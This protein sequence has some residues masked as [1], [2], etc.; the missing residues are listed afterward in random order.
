M[1]YAELA[2][3]ADTIVKDLRKR[4][5]TD[6]TRPLVLLEAT[7]DAFSVAAY[8]G[9]LR[10]GW[11][12]I[13]DGGGMAAPDTSIAQTY[14]PN[15]V[16]QFCNN[17]WRTDFGSMRQ[18]DLHPDLAVLLSKSGTTGAAK[19]VRL[20][21]H[22]LQSNA[23][24][25]ISYLK[26]RP[27][28]RT[29]TTLPFHYSYGM[30]VLHI[31]L[32][33]G[34]GVVLTERSIVEDGIWGLAKRHRVSALA[35]VPT[36]FELLNRIGFSEDWLP[37]FRYITQAGGKLD[38][39][40]LK[41][42]AH[43]ARDKGWHFFI[44]YG[45]TEAGPRMSFVPPE[46]ALDWG[47][48]IGRAIDGG[49]FHLSASD[50]PGSGDGSTTGEL[51]FEGPGVMM[52]Y[53][54]APM[55]LADGAGPSTLRTGDIA[56]R[57]DNGY[58]RLVGRASRFIK[59]FGLRIGCDEVENLLR[60]EGRRV[61]VSGSDAGLVIFLSDDAEPGSLA[62]DVAARFK[63]PPSAVVVRTLDAVPL[64]SSGKVDYRS[65]GEMAQQALSAPKPL[66]SGIETLLRTA[67]RTPE[68]DLDRSFVE[69]GGDSL[70]YLEVELFFS[71]RGTDLPE[72]WELRPLR[73]LVELDRP[74]RRSG[75]TWQSVPSDLIGRMEALVMVIALH[76]TGWPTG[77]GAYLLLILSG[78]SIA[79][80]QSEPLFAG[81]VFRTWRIMLVPIV[82]C[83]LVLVT[84]TAAVW[85]PVDWRWFLFL[86]NFVEDISPKELTPYW[87]VC[88]YVQIVLLF[89]LPFLSP[90]VRAFF[91]RSPFAAGLSSLAVVVLLAWLLQLDEVNF[92]SRHR[93]PV[94]ALE[95]FILGWCIYFARQFAQK[96]MMS[97][98]IGTVYVTH[99]SDLPNV[100]AVVILT[101]ATAPLWSLRLPATSWIARRL[102]QFGSL[103]MFV[104]LAHAPMISFVTR[105]MDLPEL[106]RFLAVLALS[107]LV[108]FVLKTA[109]T[110]IS[111]LAFPAGVSKM[112]RSAKPTASDA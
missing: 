88:A 7:N 93:H 79:R 64:L 43:C 102:M 92:S 26:V 46:D 5:P 70:S 23:T 13:L 111:S 104:Y 49:R 53:A 82:L 9:F 59:L 68:P 73:E 6:L 47:H 75:V 30:S 57:L 72:S 58:F 54:T 42:F 78:Y 100:I 84:M 67:L 27:D 112:R 65:L 2:E 25:I 41:S 37:Q 108:A 89:T 83:C 69:H 11:P 33:V 107:T 99:W 15:I 36:Q 86:G 4:L 56:E 52:G 101:G 110:S 18:Y 105:Q 109:Y 61:Y 50:G 17:A 55:H 24:A 97:A 44:M 3:R 76:S 40:L 22:N 34:A 16:I 51:V 81:A 29:V 66:S 14:A 28:G 85:A 74:G 38:P 80:F 19:L 35:F 31:H 10:A 1:S 21:R 48:T 62:Q 106:P 95:L 45:Q 60:A 90:Q 96:L 8:L 94:A 87:F 20:S 12:V 32:A 103:T 98:I 77:G 91:A 39:L 71:D 63:L